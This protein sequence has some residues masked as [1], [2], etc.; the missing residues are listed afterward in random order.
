MRYRKLISYLN[1]NFMLNKGMF[2][3]EHDVPTC[4]AIPLRPVLLVDLDSVS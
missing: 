4:C 2:T 1:I 3:E